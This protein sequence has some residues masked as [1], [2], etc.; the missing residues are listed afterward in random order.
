MTTAM[1]S[2]LDSMSFARWQALQQHQH[3]IYHTALLALLCE[4]WQNELTEHERAVLQG[5][6]LA[7]KS[8]AAVGRELGLHHS[9][10]GRIRSRTEEKLRRALAYAIRYGELVQQ[11]DD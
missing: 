10:I 6:H 3:N 2:K 7:G 9:A 1:F 4:L 11:Q 5:I 8:E